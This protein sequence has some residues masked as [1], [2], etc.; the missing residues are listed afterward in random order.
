[1]SGFTEFLVKNIASVA[2][3][4]SNAMDKALTDEN[5]NQFT[6][7]KAH[8]DD[9]GKKITALALKSQFSLTE[10]KTKNL[11]GLKNGDIITTNGY[12][13]SGDG[14]AANYMVDNAYTGVYEGGDI[15]TIGSTKLRLLHDNKINVKQFGGRIGSTYANDFTNA[16]KKIKEYAMAKNTKISIEI[17]FNVGRYY[18]NESFVVDANYTTFWSK[19]ALIDVTACIDN[20]LPYIFQMKFNKSQ[21]GFDE[22]GRREFVFDHVHFTSSYTTKVSMDNKNTVLFAFETSIAEKDTHL[23]SHMT[24]NSVIMRNVPYF[25]GIG[26]NGYLLTF[27]DCTGRICRQA[28]KVYS[29]TDPTAI[30]P[31]LDSSGYYHANWGEN[32]TFEGGMFGG[33]FEET[34]YNGTAVGSLKFK[35]T[36]I[37]Y[38]YGG[39]WLATK[40]GS[41]TSFKDCFIEHGH[42]NLP[43]PYTNDYNYYR[44]D[45]NYLML[46]NDTSRVVIDGGRFH[47]GPHSGRDGTDLKYLASTT[48]GI[49]SLVIKNCKFSNYKLLTQL[50]HENIDVSLDDNMYEG[51]IPF[52]VSK[53]N[54]LF[55]TS[56]NQD[57]A[58]KIDYFT[59]AY[60]V[61]YGSVVTQVTSQWETYEAKIEWDTTEK[62]FKI[63]KIGGTTAGINLVLRLPRGIGNKQYNLSFKTKIISG[64]GTFNAKLRYITDRQKHLV[65]AD[66]TILSLPYPLDPAFLKTLVDSS[67]LTTEY[68]QYIDGFIIPRGQYDL[69]AINLEIGALADN[70]TFYLKDVIFN[71]V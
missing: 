6:T 27:K 20:N 22:L 9:K 47:L 35:D 18:W 10:M 3:K 55:R 7:L 42:G 36:S 60:V 4:V 66:N 54:N 12:Y 8:L 41:F 61:Y 11:S 58:D 48:G 14:G 34:I 56:L 49:P 32:I 46:L 51:S 16:I 5:G 39:N 38:S 40:S 68:T 43:D 21:I 59:D 25:I 24:L 33:S 13:S 17:P 52:I 65:K 70:T 23:S 19:G 15:V 62:A 67:N 69:L 53:K 63:T 45:I 37:D 31:T 57:S 2:Y 26:R 30:N 29:W 50:V 44:T 1:M 28:I 64:S 71:R